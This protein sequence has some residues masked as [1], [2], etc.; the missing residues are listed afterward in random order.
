MPNDLSPIIMTLQPKYSANIRKRNGAVV[1]EPGW[2]QVNVNNQL[3]GYIYDPAFSAA[4][5]DNYKRLAAGN[6]EAFYAK[7]RTEVKN[8]PHEKGVT[9][10]ILKVGQGFHKKSTLTASNGER[11]VELQQS[12]KIIGYVPL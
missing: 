8:I 5:L 3:S 6:G 12:G 7:T 9:L 1:K 11:W 10:H 2:L 4:C